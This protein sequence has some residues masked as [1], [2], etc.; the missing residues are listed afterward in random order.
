MPFLCRHCRQMHLSHWFLLRQHHR[1]RQRHNLARR[2]QQFRRC[3]LATGKWMVCYQYQRDILRL[4]LL[5]IH[6][7]QA[8]RQD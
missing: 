7:F 3:C 8:M 5:L 2:R 4:R 6:R 1:R